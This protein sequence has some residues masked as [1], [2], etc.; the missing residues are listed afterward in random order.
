MDKFVTV[1]KPATNDAIHEGK[2]KTQERAKFRYNPYCVKKADERRVESWKDKKRTQKILAPLLK[3]KATPSSSALTK[4]LLHT[5]PDKSNPITHS[6]IYYRTDHIVSAATGHQRSDGRGQV[7]K[8]YVA[9]RS[10][11]LREQLP[12][13][14]HGPDGDVLQGVRVYINGYLDD[15]TDIEMKRI[16]TL[17]GGRV[18]QTASGATHVLTSQ[19][20]SGSKTQRLLATRSKIKVHVVK[21]EW[22]TDS[23]KAG[24]RLQERDYAVVMDHSSRSLASM[25]GSHSSQG[26]SS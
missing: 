6:D 11:K 20:L 9:S 26:Q 10:A 19:Q 21:P 5:L 15:T 24:K 12:D 2:N 7:N 23:I 16:V 13:R 18:L 14:L 1:T 22:V 4:H 25:F 3:E 17:A 8:D